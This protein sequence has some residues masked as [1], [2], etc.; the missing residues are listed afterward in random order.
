MYPPPPPSVAGRQGGRK[1]RKHA[2]LP[3]LKPPHTENKDVISN[4][5]HCPNPPTYKVTF[6]LRS[7][8]MQHRPSA[9]SLQVI[10]TG[11]INRVYKVNVA[12]LFTCTDR[13]YDSKLLS[14]HYFNS[15][16][17]WA[18]RQ[19]SNVPVRNGSIHC[20]LKRRKVSAMAG[21]KINYQ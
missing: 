16:R 7:I 4:T 8:Q 2:P 20:I 18:W 1:L 10:F 17:L 3:G 9:S 21:R 5:H 11:L 15:S 14:K 19:R 13:Q 6:W 12:P